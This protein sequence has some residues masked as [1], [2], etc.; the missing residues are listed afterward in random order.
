MELTGTNRPCGLRISKVHIQSFNF[1]VG[2]KSPSC[3]DRVSRVVFEMVSSVEAKLSERVGRG[4]APPWSASTETVTV[5]RTVGGLLPQVSGGE[6]RGAIP[7]PIPNSEVKT[8]RADGTARVS[9]WESR[10]LPG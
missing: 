8:S 7:D 3:T 2:S 4:N 10:K 9:V 1:R 6:V 5:P